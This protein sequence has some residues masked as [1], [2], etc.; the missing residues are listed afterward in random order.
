M[1]EGLGK[2]AGLALLAVPMVEAFTFTQAQFQQRISASKERSRQ[3][4]KCHSL[5]STTSVRPWGSHACFA[6]AS[7]AGPS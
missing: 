5:R 1:A 3:Y 6:R 4:S 7:G 2:V